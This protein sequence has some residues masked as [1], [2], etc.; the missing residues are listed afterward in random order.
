[1]SPLTERELERRLAQIEERV[2]SLEILTGI[3]VAATVAGV[4]YYFSQR[5]FGTH[6]ADWTSLVA[7]NVVFFPLI[8][9]SRRR[10][11]PN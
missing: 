6:V 9:A 11:K 4:V 7:Y 10:S 8:L 3:A 1:M 5:Y 2:Q